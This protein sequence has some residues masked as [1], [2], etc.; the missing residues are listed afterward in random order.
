MPRGGKKRELILQAAEALLRER[1]VH[2]LTMDDVAEAA[3]V[4]KGTI[5]NHFQNKD[6]L[7]FEIAVH[8]FEDLCEVVANTPA[9][10]LFPERLTSLCQHI[11][12]FF[13]KR[14]PVIRMIHE[15]EGRF[16]RLSGAM[17]DRW[18]LHR[19][20]LVQAVAS[21]LAQGVQDGTV[22]EDM[23]VERLALMMLGM[24]RARGQDYAHMPEARPTVEAVV[25]LFL[26]GA[27]TAR[28]ASATSA[29]SHTTG[30]Y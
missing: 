1:R 14:R 11:S 13:D 9:T 5:Y 20:T 25:D 18:R 23:P 6:D 2:E 28:P 7:L 4:G 10:G 16:G 8:G 3:A 15:H 17:K 30:A 29:Q 27:G 22:R 19:Q 12:D 26:H 24:M 21:V